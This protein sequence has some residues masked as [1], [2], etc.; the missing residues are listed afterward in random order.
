MSNVITYSDVMKNMEACPLDTS[1]RLTITECKNLL[2][3]FIVDRLHLFCRKLNSDFTTLYSCR[4]KAN[5][6]LWT[7]YPGEYK[8]QCR[9]YCTTDNEDRHMEQLCVVCINAYDF[10]ELPDCDSNIIPLCLDPRSVQGDKVC[11]YEYVLDYKQRAFVI[12]VL[13]LSERFV[14][15]VCLPRDTSLLTYNRLKTYSDKLLLIQHQK[16]VDTVKDY[17][18]TPREE[19]IDFEEC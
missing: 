3:T 19:P 12:E 1:M 10:T 8:R 14:S 17:T 11:T 4:V 5:N 18:V 16:E 2:D 13:P 15:G 6:D 7:T 9:V